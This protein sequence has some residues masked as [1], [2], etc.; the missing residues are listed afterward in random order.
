MFIAQK[1]SSPRKI[2]EE[3]PLEKSL[4]EKIYNSRRESIA[5][6]SN[7]SQKFPV[8]IGPCS[9]HDS[10][11]A[12]KYALFLKEMQEKLGDA[13]FLVM[14]AYVEKP[15]WN[16]I[17]KWRVSRIIRHDSEKMLDYLGKPKTYWNL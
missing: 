6:T 16:P 2:K 1:I 13:L 15:K 12:L 7:R 11:S 8:I 5:I 14:R 3:I 10:K 9:I 17:L 4:Q